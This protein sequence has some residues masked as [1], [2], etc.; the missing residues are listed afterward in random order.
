MRSSLSAAAEI[1]QALVPGLLIAAGLIAGVCLVSYAASAQT[2]VR[3]NV[4]YTQVGK[5]C[6]ISSNGSA[7]VARDAQCPK[8]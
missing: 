1:T 8:S 6:V 4:K 3:G 5:D 7:R 2:T